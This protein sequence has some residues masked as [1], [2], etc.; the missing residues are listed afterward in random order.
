[1]EQEQ[2][3]W[4]DSV[5][6]SLDGMRRAEMPAALRERILQHAPTARK[7]VAILRQPVMWAMAAALALLIGFNVY[8]L[9]RHERND[10]STITMQSNPVAN[11]YFTLPPS[12]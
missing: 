2:Q 3:K 12:I 4:T 8:S 9:V 5:L 10:S 7:R 11:E 6:N 1:M